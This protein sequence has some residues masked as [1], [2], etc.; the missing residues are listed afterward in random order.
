LDKLHIYEKLSTIFTPDIHPRNR[1]MVRQKS[2]D[3]PETQGFR[4]VDLS[5]VFD[6]K[7]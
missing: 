6:N 5:S 3:C 4:D 2:A 7:L 1:Y